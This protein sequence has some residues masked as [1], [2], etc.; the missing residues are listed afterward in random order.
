MR[1]RLPSLFLVSL[2]LLA[3][4]VLPAAARAE[5]LNRI[6]LR[7][8]DQIATLYDYEQRRQ[9]LV[10]DVGRREQ[11]DPEERKRL[12]AEA[13]EIA[14]KD[15]FQDVLLESRAKQLAVEVS[16][17]QLEAALATMKQNFGLKTDEDFK[18]ALAQSGLTLEQLRDQIRN[19]IRVREV[20]DKEVRSRIKVNEEDLR[21][22]YRKNQEQFRVPEQFHL[23]EV[24]VLDEGGLP[25]AEE[26]GRVAAEIRQAV[27]GGKSLADATA[28]YQKK[29]VTSNDIDLGWVSPGDLDPALQTAAWKLKPGGVSDPVAGRG[30]L[31][32]L[33][34]VEHRDSRIPPFSEVSAA[35]QTREQERVYSQEVNKYLA[36]LEQKSFVVVD[37]PAEAAGFRRLLT[38]PETEA[39]PE[40]RDL[41]TS[42]QVG[43]AAAAAAAN[44]KEPSKQTPKDPLKVPGADPAGAQPGALPQPKPVTNTP[45]P[46]TAE[47]PSAAPKPPPA[48]PAKP[49]SL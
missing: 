48:P 42:A 13:P 29:G 35:I 41:R 5:A 4:L 33:Q 23:R 12:L 20:M 9:D 1:R 37:P 14:F 43:A 31:H 18:A 19:Q 39:P 34:A 17:S 45:P 15:M 11:M 6:V 8:N 21:R 10:R 40:L 16:D 46:V 26:R 30:G 28:E 49:P 22:Y 25:T 38:R 32:L 36:E 24:V 47:P 3:P 44:A 27:T 7:I 2:V